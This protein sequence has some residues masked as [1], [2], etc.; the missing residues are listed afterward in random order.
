MCLKVYVTIEMITL[1]YY[2]DMHL[3]T[4]TKVTLE[5]NSDSFC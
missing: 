2:F 5:A 3:K 4:V 1:Q